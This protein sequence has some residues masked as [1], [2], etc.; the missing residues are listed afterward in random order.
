MQGYGWGTLKGVGS[1]EL[2]VHVGGIEATIGPADSL[3]SGNTILTE[4]ATMR[5]G[6]SAG[7]SDYYRQSRLHQ[8]D[9]E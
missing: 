6:A 4:G 7:L 5:P 3:V 8:A 1:P 2:I 9:G